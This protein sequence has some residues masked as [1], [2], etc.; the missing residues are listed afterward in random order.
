MARCCDIGDVYDKDIGPN[1]VG[2]GVRCAARQMKVSHVFG[3]CQWRRR[4][5]AS[6]P[7]LEASL[8]V[9]AHFP[10]HMLVW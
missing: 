7:S 5:W 1:S 2:R 10:T 8:C 4:M 6:F 3:W 9:L